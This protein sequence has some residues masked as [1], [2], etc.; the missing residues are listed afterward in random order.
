MVKNILIAIIL[1]PFVFLAF[2]PKK[3][4]LYMAEDKLA[5]VGVHIADS[6]IGTNP[7][8]ITMEHPSIY[9]KGIK[10][11]TVERISLW[12]LW[13]YTDLKVDNI[14]IDATLK[15]YLPGSID[16][17]SVKHSI[18]DPK[19]IKITIEDKDLHG[20]GTVDLSLRE[21]HLLFD[22]L[23]SSSPLKAHMKKAQ[24]GWIYE[25]QF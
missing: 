16:H 1:F 5:P 4:L 24:G 7:F 21:I 15:A 20:Q 18:T 2:A 9:F 8:G 25:Q 23:P 13:V 22:K 3:S 14:S 19:Q 6:E 17:I 10:V 12:T 11:A